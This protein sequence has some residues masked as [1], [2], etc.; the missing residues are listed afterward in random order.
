M[1]TPNHADRQHAK[2][3][4]SR[5]HRVR[6]CAGYVRFSAGALRAEN[7]AAEAGTMAHEYLAAKLS[8]ELPPEGATEDIKRG[9]DVVLDYLESVA[10]LHP[11][12]LVLTSEEPL[13]FPQNVVPAEEA[14]G[15]ADIMLHDP[16][17]REAWAIEYKHGHAHVSEYRNPQLLFNATAKWWN[18]PL[19]RV[20]LVVIQPN[21][22]RGDIVREDIV[23]P[24]DL[25]EFQREVEEV[26]RAAES[27]DAP[28]T[29]GPHCRY[30]ERELT[31]PSRER[32]AL[33]VADPVVQRV[34]DMDSLTLPAPA[35]IPLD[36]LAYIL[37]NANALREWLNAAENH[38]YTLALQGA[39]VPDHKLVETQAWR[40]F[41]D[42]VHA[43]AARLSALTSGALE[44]I[45]FT[46]VK[47]KGVTKVEAILSEFA[48]QQA[49]PGTQRAAVKDMKDRLAF[50]TPRASSG[51]L[52]LV[53]M[54]DRRPAALTKVAA[55]FAG[56]AV[57]LPPT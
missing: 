9:V 40:Q 38:A 19:N 34:E 55:G 18:T 24:V 47:L 36:R 39:Q 51:N 21:G 56:L 20:H 57:P 1:H 52:T 14:A 12:S 27:P 32:Q 29:A 4:S 46:E 25:A 53:H 8:G 33:A 16:V 42:D 15:I 28:L 37:R 31:C 43:T 17:E 13:I 11:R 45:E 48:A 26:I 3:S 2:Y 10:I 54:S 30:C 5:I 23:G 49:A 41:P 35:T 6:G 7:D 50:L 44:P 22:H